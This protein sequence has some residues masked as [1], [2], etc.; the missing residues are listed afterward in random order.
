MNGIL[1][2]ELVG[3]RAKAICLSIYLYNKALGV[4]ISGNRDAAYNKR[5]Y[6]LSQNMRSGLQRPEDPRTQDGLIQSPP[7]HQ[8]CKAGTLQ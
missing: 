3:E 2:Y 8:V 7:Y 1:R 5:P 4:V 6:N